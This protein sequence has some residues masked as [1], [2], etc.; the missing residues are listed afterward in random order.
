MSDPVLALGGASRHGV[1]RVQ[2]HGPYGMVTVR[3][4]L[5]DSRVSA[6]LE[7]ATGASMPDRR[8]AALNDRKGIAWMS[9]DEAM[10]VC[11]R[12][13]APRI[14]SDLTAA[15]AGVHHLAVDVSD[16]RAVFR[17]E[18]DPGKLRDVLA[19]LT[20]A[21]M[22]AAAFPVGEI[23]RTR[24]AQVPA[25]IWMVHADA[26]YVLCFRS[27]AGYVFDLLGVAVKHGSLPGHFRVT[28]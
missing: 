28:D 8:R 22:R 10:V 17:L 14:V 24:L 9:P 12:S 20:P 2:E 16:A 18:G 11:A 23:R 1:V 7:A 15:L 4:D 21:D 5:A 6:A 19:K 27:V 26:A 13:E 25:A 3:G